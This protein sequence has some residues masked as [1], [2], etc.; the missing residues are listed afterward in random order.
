MVKAALLTVE[1]PASL[2]FAESLATELDVNL[3]V[4]T[5]KIFPDGESY[6]R[7]P[8]EVLDE[9]VVVLVYSMVPPQDKSIFEILL[10]VDALKSKS[11]DKVVLVAPYMA[12]SRQ[13]REFLE[14]EGVSIRT[15]LR[16]LRL[17][18]VDSLYTIEIHKR[19]SLR[20]FG[21]KAYSISPYRFMAKRLRLPNEILVLAPDLGAVE[22]AKE[23]AQA[24]NASYDYLVKKRDPI[25]GDITLE[26][27]RVSVEG[28]E[29]VIVDDII[30]TGGTI[31]K[32]ARMLLDQGAKSIR[33]VAAHALMVGNAL[34][35]IE[36]AGVSRVYAANTLPKIESGLIE[37]I[38]VAPIVANALRSTLLY[39]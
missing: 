8:S 23:F 25:T 27:K 15:L 33:V 22:R 35:K 17:I 6:I 1:E 21:E 38:D 31:A 9:N 10:S 36:N 20:Y 14:N 19:E 39:P 18:G 24:I 7:L 32:A 5:R 26:P 3:Y 30:S 16:T 13:D 4:L 11:I 28:E 2:E 12:Y 29:V 37:Y 34:E